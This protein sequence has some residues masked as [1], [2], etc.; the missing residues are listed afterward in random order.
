MTKSL[1]LL[2][3]FVLT[4]SA[5]A[6]IA[7]Q[8]TLATTSYDE[9]R[10]VILTELKD[11]KD[12]LRAIEVT[13][14][15]KNRA[16]IENNQEEISF[17]Y[18]RYGFLIGIK[19]EVEE[20]IAALDTAINIAEANELNEIALRAHV[21]KAVVY[22]SN[23]L[24]TKSIDSYYKALE[25]A[26]QE[27]D[28]ATA[29]GITNTLGWIKGNMEDYDG[30][31]EILRRGLRSVSDEN[32]RID[33]K[34][35]T[36]RELKISFNLNIAMA[37]RKARRLDSTLL[38]INRAEEIIFLPVD[39]CYIST[40][41][42]LKA[43]TLV[44]KND[45]DEAS[46]YLKKSTEYCRPKSALD[47]LRWSNTKGAI[48]LGNKKYKEA[49]NVLN[50]GLKTYRVTPAE[51]KFMADYYKTLAKAYKNVG[52]VDSA[53]YFLEKHLNT[54][55]K[56]ND[57]RSGLSNSF[58][59]QE[60]KE[61]QKELIELSKQKSQKENLLLYGGIAGALIIL[62]LVYG[63][64]RSNKKRKENEDKFN[65]LEAKVSA[66]KESENIIDTKDEVLEEQTT[67]DVNPETTQL[68]LDGLK[69]LEE[70]HYFLHPACSAPNV[71]KRIKTNTTY[72]SKV[73]NAQFGKNFST[74]INDLRINYAIKRLKQ[75][76]KFRNYT[77]S[78]I[79]TELGYKSADSFT[80]YFK[81]DTGLLPS[82]YIKKLNKAA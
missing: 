46:I 34:I 71:A 15:H 78:S 2:F 72:L 44:D 30:A 54:T 23:F 20:S 41:F 74:Y 33:K 22:D 7:Q 70:Q 10:E 4:L 58:R 32:I 69:K 67:S 45:F 52:M 57:L 40:A 19:G 12:T 31:I 3:S 42:E 55:S 63:L 48:Y 21:T 25:L 62:V 56:S 5:S 65:I 26:Y 50:K 6:S 75:D 77:I 1:H 36:R 29:F 59:K 47:S 9:L 37:H 28:Y 66:A 51:E 76:P 60:I 61:F 80:K 39:S 64:F 27:E 11:K 38:Y 73:I 17:G 35:I 43:N 79:A 49:I 14:Y 53:N 16:I 82:F 13:K 18:G 8:D 81:K 24:I 68:I